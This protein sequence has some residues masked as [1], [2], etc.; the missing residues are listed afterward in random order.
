M[1]Y[2]ENKPMPMIPIAPMTIPMRRTASGIA[3]MP[4]P[5]LPFSIC[6]MVSPYLTSKYIY[7]IILYCV[8]ILNTSITKYQVYKKLDSNNSGFIIIQLHMLNT[9]T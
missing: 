9:A 8:G 1:Q 6:I 4:A 7:R 2:V 5:M 3:S